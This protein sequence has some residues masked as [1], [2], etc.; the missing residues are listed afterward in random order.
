MYRNLKAEMARADITGD[1]LAKE[2]GITRSTMSRK[3]NGMNEF[4]LKQA[5]QIK[6]I[7]KTDMALEYLFDRT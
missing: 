1:D 6:A 2:L 7:L 5:M 3:I 4:T